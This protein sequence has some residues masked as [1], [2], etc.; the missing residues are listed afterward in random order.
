MKH[1]PVLATTTVVLLSTLTANA[2]PIGNP[3]SLASNAPA[4]VHKPEKKS[5][6]HR[7]FLP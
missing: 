4:A 2:R 7:F 6:P 5:R 3:R 1:L